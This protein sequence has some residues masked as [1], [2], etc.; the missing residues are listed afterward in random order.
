MSYLIEYANKFIMEQDDGI[1]QIYTGQ[2]S[3]HELLTKPRFD[4]NKIGQRE[5]NDQ[6]GP[7][8][9]FTTN[10]QEAL[11][12]AYP[13]GIIVTAKFKGN[14][15]ISVNDEI[16]N[17]HVDKMIEQAPDLDDTLANW[18]YDPGYSSKEDALDQ[19]KDAI[20]SDDNAK[21]IWLA[22]WYELYHNEPKQ[23]VENMIKL[24]YDGLIVTPKYSDDDRKH[25]VMYNINAIDVTDVQQYKDL[26]SDE[27]TQQNESINFANKWM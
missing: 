20:Y 18:G 17:D 23:F 7:G 11:G 5:A 10:P 21:D 24:G 14:N 4:L 13:N 1:D 16:N 2:K 27:E 26:I 25:I 8:F 9:Y 19:L 3:R 12:Y 22:V 15:L 6:E